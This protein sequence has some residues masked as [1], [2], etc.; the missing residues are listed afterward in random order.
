MHAHTY[1]AHLHLGILLIEQKKNNTFYE[2]LDAVVVIT[3]E[4]PA[5]PPVAEVYG[6]ANI[7]S[8]DNENW[9]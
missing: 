4:G 3:I 8:V 6:D 5:A 7:I 9:E 1:I 2:V